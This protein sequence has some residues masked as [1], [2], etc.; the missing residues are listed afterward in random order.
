MIF[1]FVS[2]PC[3]TRIV[4][5][6]VSDMAS[7]SFLE[8]IVSLFVSNKSFRGIKG[9]RTFVNIIILKTVE[10]IKYEMV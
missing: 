9:S 10:V 8:E 6:F 3:L 4:S 5:D 7:D 1:V 2:V